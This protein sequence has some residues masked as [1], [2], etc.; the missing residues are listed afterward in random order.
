MA[1]DFSFRQG[2]TYTHCIIVTDRHAGAPVDLT[3]GG[4]TYASATAGLSSGTA[5]VIF[6]VYSGANPILTKDTGGTTPLLASDIT[7]AANPIAS[8]TTT[9]CAALIAIT[10][11]DASTLVAGSYT[12]EVRVILNGVQKVVY[13]LIGNT[14]SLTVN[15]SETWNATTNLPRVE[16]PTLKA[17]AALWGK[18]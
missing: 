11:A 14:A 12:Y 6:T 13:P 3:N 5:R 7:I 10:T 8:I 17:P 9:K 2:E 1:N 4:K 16:R 18:V 15:P